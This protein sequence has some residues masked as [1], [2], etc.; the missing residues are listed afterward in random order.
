[1]QGKN[2][3]LNTQVAYFDPS[4][5]QPGDFDPS[6]MQMP[7]FAYDPNSFDPSMFGMM[8]GPDG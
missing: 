2:D 3:V 8:M 1:M 6:K 5:P 4:N 7:D